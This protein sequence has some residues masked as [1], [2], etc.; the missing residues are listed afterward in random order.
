MAEKK[1]D[2]KE[3]PFLNSLLISALRNA[4]EAVRR[5]FNTPFVRE[6]RQAQALLRSLQ[7][8]SRTFR[9]TETRPVPA[10]GSTRARIA[11]VDFV[12]TALPAVNKT[13]YITN[14][15]TPTTNPTFDLSFQNLEFGPANV[16][17]PSGETVR[18]PQGDRGTR[19]ASIYAA[20]PN[21]TRVK[22]AA[23]Q[24]MVGNLVANETPSKANWD[25]FPTTKAR[26]RLYRRW[27]EGAFSSEKGMRVN[28]TTW[29]SRDPK[30]R[31]KPTVTWDPR[32]LQAPLENLASRDVSRQVAINTTL[33]RI[34][35]PYIQA[36]IVAND[37]YQGITGNSIFAD[38]MQT[39][40]KSLEANPKQNVG[41]LL[42]F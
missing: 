30:G 31:F 41:P 22:Q 20:D 36:A 12:R 7:S 14:L 8:G 25:I 18:L 39:M 40:T 15:D 21:M 23:L 42:P 26:G 27:S 5:N 37:L 11:N 24:W 10:R 6:T 1:K 2:K 35:N 13:A 4:G 17:M 19:P 3:T 28:E 34:N 29:Q 9:G 38:Q 33:R 16:R 32:N